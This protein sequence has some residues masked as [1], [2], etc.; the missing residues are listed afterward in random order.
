M[1][2]ATWLSGSEPP[3]ALPLTQ[4]ETSKKLSMQWVLRRS[5][6]GCNITHGVM[7]PCGLDICSITPRGEEIQI[8]FMKAHP[9]R[10][11][12]GWTSFLSLCGASLSTDTGV[13]DSR[14][15]QLWGQKR[16]SWT[17]HTEPRKGWAHDSSPC[18]GTQVPV[19]SHP[20]VMYRSRI[21][22][23]QIPGPGCGTK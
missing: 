21:V 19:L 10:Q 11:G 17:V 20:T 9:G 13:M 5:M 22:E 12:R 3:P 16:C 8:D 2:G 23:R 14:G 1:P 15:S 7:D 18:G 4:T 6:W